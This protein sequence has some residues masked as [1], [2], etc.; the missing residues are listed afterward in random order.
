M[1]AILGGGSTDRGRARSGEASRDHAREN[2]LAMREAAKVNRER[3]EAEAAPPARL[4]KMK[5]FEN[6]PSRALAAAAKPAAVRGHEEGEFLRRGARECA[7]TPAEV[8]AAQA[9]RKVGAERRRCGAG[10]AQHAVDEDEL[11]SATPRPVTPRKEAVPR[12]RDALKPKPHEN[13]VCFLARN[14]AVAMT[15]QVEQKRRAPAQRK[16][17]AVGPA[18]H[19]DFGAVPAY[20][21]DRKATLAANAERARRAAPDPDAPP[22]M[23]R[24]DDAERKDLVHTLRDQKRHLDD[25]LFK[26]P[27]NIQSA[28]HK[29]Q[30]M[31][32]EQKVK[33]VEKSLAIFDRAVVYIMP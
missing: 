25:A 7:P 6:V 21:A 16:S 1:A 3:R 9:K 5:Q 19:G 10:A 32:L 14:R 13:E 31:D 11:S 26:L 18:K 17:D 20:L 24:M 2:V 28:R 23:V 15:S 27:L 4:Y 22:G 33:D 8:A 30:Q 12:A 29:K